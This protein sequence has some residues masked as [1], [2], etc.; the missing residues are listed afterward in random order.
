MPLIL[1]STNANKKNNQDILKRVTI[2][3]QKRSYCPV[4]KN[5]ESS[6][7]N[8]LHEIE[9][10]GAFL[11]HSGDLLS[12]HSMD[13]FFTFASPAAQALLGYE[14]EELLGLCLYDLCH[15]ADRAKVENLHSCNADD[16]LYYRICRKEGDYIWLETTCIPFLNAEKSEGFSCISRDVTAQKTAEEEL[17][18]SKEKYRI[19]VENF[20][21]TVGIITNDGIWLY[22]NDT[23]RKLFGV[24]RKEEI[25]GK[26]V[27]EFIHPDDRQTVKNHLL[28][29]RSKEPIELIVSRHDHQIK[30]VEVKLIP[31]VYKDRNTYQ[32]LLRDL[33]ERKKTEEMMQQTEK[34]SVVGQLAAGIAHEIRNP[35]TAIKGFIQLIQ[36]DKQNEYL[37]IVMSELKRI[38]NIVND[39]LILAKPQTSSMEYVDLNKILVNVTQLLQ[40]EA[41]LRSVELTSDIELPDPFIKGEADK[42]QQV[43]INLIKNAI[44]AM[45]N[46]GKISLKAK[47]L[48]EHAIMTQ[49]SDNGIGV[50]PERLPKLGE[51][52]YSTKEKG[53]GLGLM[54]CNRIIKNHK[55]TLKIESKLDEGT[56]IT[57][58]LPK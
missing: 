8:L 11:R 54:I 3:V 50:S 2:K 32:I 5:I 34:L 47:Q 45:P 39:L 16:R 48:S 57:I 52:F 51:P 4:S 15:P 42:L 12:C 23:G 25:I 35:L 26:Y 6:N 1:V 36:Q 24:T 28:G 43:Y 41:L 29:E 20:Q 10:Y 58:Q 49:V 46:G 22:I 27:F 38:E 31:T 30:H 17:E 18:E 9:I 14:P 21:D 40:S 56:T 33:T 44:E 19:L 13:G 53:T 55:G 7:Q 37:K